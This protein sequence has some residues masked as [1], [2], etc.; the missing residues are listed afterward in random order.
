M[1]QDLG[2][3][4]GVGVNPGAHQ[5]DQFGTTE[6]TPEQQK[7]LID[8]R[9]KKTE[10]LL[11]IQ[12]LKDELGEVVAEME[13]MEGGGLTADETKPSNKAK[14]TSIG[15]KKFNMDPK[16]GI[17]YLIEHNLLAPTPEDVAQFLYKGEGLNKTAIGDY[18]GERHDFNERVLRAF[19]E[20]HDFTD[21]IL[22]QAL[23]QF[24]WS[25]RLPGE[26][27]KIDRMMECFAQ[28][29]CQ[30]NPNI[31]TN[32]DTCYVLSFAII[33]LNTSLHNPS[34]K[35]KPSVEQFISMN[36][37]INNGGDLPRELLVSLYESIKTEPFKIPEDDGND[38]MHTFFNPDKE[39]WLWKQA[40]GRYKSWKRRWFILND[41]CLY[42][43]EYTT[44]KEPRG[45]IPLE[46]IQVREIQ[47]RH[48]PHCFEL[49]AAGSEFIKAC[50]TDSEGKVVE[51][52]HTVYR[53]SAATD[54]EK[55]EWIKCVRQSISHNPF[56]DMLAARKKKAQ[57][58]NVHSKS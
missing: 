53:M 27:Q 33:M 36:R 19:V 11:E 6:L 43:F 38:L 29:Y 41:N 31:F 47:D 52:K 21:L 34:V 39:G 46:N 30:L 44:D 15:R 10:L 42:Y 54:E 8:I 48:K 2:G 28:R 45:I 26:A 35:D 5:V 55:D 58:T 3:L 40:G 24:L 57:K 56:Y 50:K 49:Y 20:L 18:L 51:G 17:E 7:I 16:K 4:G 13:A 23:R 25:F 14:Q 12:Q 1:W 22:V 9:R 37:G 32:T